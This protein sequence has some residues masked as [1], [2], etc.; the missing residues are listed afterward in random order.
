MQSHQYSES[1]TKEKF[2]TRLLTRWR[3]FLTAILSGYFGKV[4]VPLL[5]FFVAP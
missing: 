4:K 3:T 1:E 2:T 5:L